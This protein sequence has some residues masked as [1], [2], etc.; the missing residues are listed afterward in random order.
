MLPLEKSK[1]I[2]WTGEHFPDLAFPHLSV[3]ERNKVESLSR[4]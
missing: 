3:P 1:G 2:V 4:V